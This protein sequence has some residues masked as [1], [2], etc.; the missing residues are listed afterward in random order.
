MPEGWDLKPHQYEAVEKMHNGCVLTGGV[1]VGKS[2]TA[3][4]YWYNKVCG[5]VPPGM[6]SREPVRMERPRDVYVITTAR[7]RNDLDWLDEAVRFGVGLK[8][9]SAGVR[10]TVDSWNNISQYEQVAGAF[11]VFDEQR[12]VGDGAW[13]RT[14][15][16]LAKHNQWV[17]LSATPG[18]NWLDL[19]PIFIANGFY[20]NR[21][22]FIEAHVVHT[23]FGGYPKVQ[24]YVDQAPLF[25]YRRRVLVDMPYERHT[26]RHT[27]DYLVAF[28]EERFA[29]VQ[30]KRWNVYTQ[31]PL[32]DVGEMFRVMRKLVN[33]DPSRLGALL[34]L[35][36]KHPR[37]IVFYNFDYELDMLRSLW[38]ATGVPIAE[39]NGHK[40]EQV[41][42]GDKW[43]YLVQY[44]A[45][46]EA[47]NC[48]T[49]D[50]I[51]FYSQNYSY[52]VMEQAKG[53]IDRLNTP[54]TDLH[55][56]IFRS[57]SFIDNAIRKA[58]Q[59]K[60]N[61]NEKEAMPQWALAA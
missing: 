37:I 6:E 54:Y 10:I 46:N 9:N 49:T 17:V 55:Y 5:G 7:K 45:G 57:N 42:T 21:S 14:F 12:L 25:A 48:I 33:S 11:F 27:E 28:D 32:K 26:V 1:G 44:T 4:Y 34:K 13:V 41:P 23:Y 24:R 19:A 58:I 52:K 39:W 50:T 29:Q 59:M 30:K 35:M 40:H 47:W 43:L 8:T 61:F 3:L 2:I 56:Y 38:S 53:R 18:D 22:A 15:L 51:V 60:K 36:E 20:K 31:K 16:R